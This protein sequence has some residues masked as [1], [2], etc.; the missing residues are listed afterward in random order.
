[1]YTIGIGGKGLRRVT[2][3][4]AGDYEPAWSPDGKLIAFG[5]DGAI[6]ATSRGGK[7]TRLTSGNDNDSSPAWRPVQPT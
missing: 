7:L 6:Y 5:R 1:M 2:S 3:S 4:A